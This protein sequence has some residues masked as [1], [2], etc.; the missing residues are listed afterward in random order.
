MLS[1][2]QPASAAT[3]GTY[4][5]W[6]KQRNGEDCR[7]EPVWD[8][9]SRP[10]DCSFLL[11]LL[12]FESSKL[13]RGGNGLKSKCYQ[14]GAGSCKFLPL[15]THIGLLVLCARGF[16]CCGE[17]KVVGFHR[18]AWM[19]LRKGVGHSLIDS[20]AVMSDSGHNADYMT[21][22]AATFF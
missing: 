22:L 5:D 12:K 14:C 4:I 21:E 2:P 13:E 9:G 3:T 20:T 1:L 8:L 11:R 17:A 10:K 19:R 18:H 16:C 6:R 15:W 7:H